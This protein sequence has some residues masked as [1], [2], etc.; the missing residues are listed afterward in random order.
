MIDPDEIREGL[1]RGEFL[2][3][4]LPIV[5]LVDGQCIGAEALVRWRRDGVLLQPLE[6]IPDAE[7]TAASG[8]ITYWVIDTV[9]SEMGAWLRTNPTAQIAINVPPEVL[10]RGALVYAAEKSG[11]MEFAAQVVLE[12]TERGVPDRQAVESINTAGRF[13]V[14]VALD[15]LTLQGPGTLAVLGHAHF[16]IVKLDRSLAAQISPQCP[17]PEWLDEV[18]LLTQSTRLAVVAEGIE[19]EQQLVTIRA[20]GVQFAQGFYF[21]RPLA[22][23]DFLAFHRDASVPWPGSLPLAPPMG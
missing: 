4:Y 7:Q 13:D 3:E 2:L 10:G 9:A 8:L 18:A 17:R 1:G 12:M 14:R 23:D 11:L 6:F 15:D 19:T 22:A 5:S 16:D 20:A 21:S